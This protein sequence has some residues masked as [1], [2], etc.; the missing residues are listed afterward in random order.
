MKLNLSMQMNFSY[1]C[2]YC[3]NKSK[4]NQNYHMNINPEGAELGTELKRTAFKRLAL[5]KCRW[6]DNLARLSDIT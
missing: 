1:S 5:T 2:N 4:L 6:S 3:G